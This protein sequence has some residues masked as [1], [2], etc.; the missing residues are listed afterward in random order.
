VHR[1]PLYEAAVHLA[2]TFQL[3]RNRE[4]ELLKEPVTT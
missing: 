1:L 4:E 2:D 3:P